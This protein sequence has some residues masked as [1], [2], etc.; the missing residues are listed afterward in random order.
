ME[1]VNEL[2]D[3]FKTTIIKVN[4]KAGV[5][6]LADFNN[7]LNYCIGKWRLKV[8]PAKK[9]SYNFVAPVL[10]VHATTYGHCFHRHQL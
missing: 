10:F 2:P 4:G 7:L 1:I 6:W 3:E 5:E 9:L 8:L